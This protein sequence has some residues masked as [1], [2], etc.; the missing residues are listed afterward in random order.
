ME[1]LGGTNSL[2]S[3]DV[4][5]TVLE[6]LELA[7]GRKN[8]LLYKFVVTNTVAIDRD[9]INFMTVCFALIASLSKSQVFF[10]ILCL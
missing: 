4:G 8:C 9:G 6:I 5:F 1:G 7:A 10:L 2:G 3:S